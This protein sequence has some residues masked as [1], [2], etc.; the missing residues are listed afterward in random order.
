MIKTYSNSTSFTRSSSVVCST[1]QSEWNNAWEFI[2]LARL[3]YIVNYH[4]NESIRTWDFFKL[5]PLVSARLNRCA[6]RLNNRDIFFNMPLRPRMLDTIL[7]TCYMHRLYD[8]PNNKDVMWCGLRERMKKPNDQDPLQWTNQTECNRF[9]DYC[10]AMS[11]V[12]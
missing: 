8:L 9:M 4:I 12:R 6:A 2:K 5:I 11:E 1:A 7:N 3:A 10:A